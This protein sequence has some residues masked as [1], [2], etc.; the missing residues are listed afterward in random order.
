M[1]IWENL[2]LMASVYVARFIVWRMLRKRR[3][4]VQSSRFQRAPWKGNQM[5]DLI[6]VALTIAFFVL[7]V[8]YVLGCDR[9]KGESK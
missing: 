1:R 7:A 8:F 6:F 2:K 5:T 3:S 9:L 4:R